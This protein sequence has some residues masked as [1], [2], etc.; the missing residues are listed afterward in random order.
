MPRRTLA[1]WSALPLGDSPTVAVRSCDGD[2]RVLNEELRACCCRV[3]NSVYGSALPCTS[4]F[5]LP[6]DVAATPEEDCFL[7]LKRSEGCR[8]SSLADTGGPA[9]GPRSERTDL[10]DLDEPCLHVTQT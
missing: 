7:T 10:L 2:E 4:S 3:V 9:D 6:P 1:S 8:S 5:L